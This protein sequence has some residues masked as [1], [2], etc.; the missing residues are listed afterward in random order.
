MLI[1]VVKQKLMMFMILINLL[2]IILKGA[3][4]TKSGNVGGALFQ[5]LS[6]VL[7]INQNTGWGNLRPGGSGIDLGGGFT[8]TDSKGRPKTP[9]QIAAEKAKVA[10]PKSKTSP[11]KPPVKSNPKVVYGPPV[12]TTG[13]FGQGNKSAGSK[14]PSFSANY[15]KGM[16]SKTET[17]GLMR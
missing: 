14:P 11:V 12:P 8:P 17:L 16:R 10:K 2:Q 6:G 1:K 4:C 15:P 13:R 5:G 3:I 9:Q 7:R